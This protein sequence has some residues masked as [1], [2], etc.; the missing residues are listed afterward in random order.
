MT[1]QK[2]SSFWHSFYN[3]QHFNSSH[4]QEMN[5]CWSKK[6]CRTM[7]SSESW[8]LNSCCQYSIWSIEKVHYY[9]NKCSQQWYLNLHLQISQHMQQTKEH[10]LWNVKLSNQWSIHWWFKDVLH[11]IHSNE[12][13]WS[14]ESS[15]KR[16]NHQNK[17]QT[18]DELV[19][20]QSHESQ[21]E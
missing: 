19:N 21:K 5:W 12:T 1:S 13:E 16:K 6:W 17:S 18:V 7:N 9:L 3:D 8:I 15:E 4:N 10:E 14:S 2:Q 11:D 20:H